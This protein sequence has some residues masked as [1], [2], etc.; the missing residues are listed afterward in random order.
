MPYPTHARRLAPV[1]LSV[2]CAALAVASPAGTA[3]AR[4]PMS[5]PSRRPTP[6]VRKPAR[7]DRRNEPRQV[8][9]IQKLQIVDVDKY[10]NAIP[11]CDVLVVGGGLGGVAAAEALAR[12]GATVI[13][14][15][16]TS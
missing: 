11:T 14:T 2:C 6:A 5:G 16:P 15:E 7:P 8:L 3:P 1:A 9:D 4:S 13:L 12:Q 10:P